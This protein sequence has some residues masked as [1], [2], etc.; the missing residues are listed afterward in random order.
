M[1]RNFYTQ[2]WRVT[3]RGVLQQQVFGG[4]NPN[5]GPDDDSDPPIE[6]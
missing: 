5:L 2:S 1:K 4:W 3:Q 6:N